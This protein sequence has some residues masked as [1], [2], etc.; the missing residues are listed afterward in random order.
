MK[1]EVHTFRASTLQEALHLVR[2]RLGPRAAV[3]A[4]RPVRRWG[5]FPTRCVEVQA[6]CDVA[7]QQ[8]GMQGPGERAIDGEAETAVPPANRTVRP[9]QD[10]APVE[11]ERRQARPRSIEARAPAAAYAQRG[12]SFMD[13][14]PPHSAGSAAAEEEGSAPHRLPPAMLEMMIDLTEHGV[15]PEAARRLLQESFQRCDPAQRN[16]P[17]MVRAAVHGALTR[18]LSTGGAVHPRADTGRPTV[19]ALVGPTGVGKTTTLAKIAAAARFDMGMRVGMVS[20]DTFRMGA[21]DQLRQYAE[22]ISAPLEVATDHAQVQS[23]LDR[24]QN[25]D[26]VLIDTAGRAPRDRTQHRR[27][28]ELLARAQPDSVQLVL[29]ASAAPQHARASL[30]AFGCVSPTHL[31]V[32]KLDEA[33]QFGAWLPLLTE[34]GLPISYLTSGQRVPEDIVVATPRRVGRELLGLEHAAQDLEVHRHA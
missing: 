15:P 10:R 23:A 33:V 30:Q 3:I 25:Q 24:L 22:L 8:R 17:W 1:T 12:G 16:D 6:T 28:A 7:A 31:V 32:T 26:L 2:Q 11:E 4:T 27:L 20:L 14:A 13:A 29:S 19:I 18:T 9:D 21:V 5:V 34:C